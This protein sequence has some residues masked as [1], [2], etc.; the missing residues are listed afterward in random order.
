MINGPLAGKILRFAVPLMLSSVLQLLF[1]AA[2]VAVVGRFA[3]KDA[4]AAVGSTAVISHMLVSLGTSFSVGT[5]I[6]ISRDLGS[7][8]QDNT[9]C[10]V[11]T[12]VTLALVCG[13]LLGSISL[14]LCRPIL[15][16]MR[17][18]ADVIDLSALYL[19]LYFLG[20]PAIMLYNFGAAILR[21]Q[22]DTK[23]PLY[24]LTS[25]GIIN[26]CLNLLFV[27]VFHMSVAGVALATIASQ[28]ISAG[29]VF[30]TL[31]RE[32]GP[33]HLDPKKLR[34]DKRAVYRILKVGIPAG[35]QS[36]IF[37]VS[38]MAGQSAINSLNSTAVMAASSTGDNIAGFVYIS[39]NAFYQA[40]Q[41]F[42]SQNYGAGKCDRVDKVTVLSMLYISTAGLVLGNLAYFFGEELASLYVPGEQE[43]IELT[44][45]Y[46]RI[47]ALPYFICGLMEVPVGVMRSIGY[48]TL[49][50]IVYS[51]GV[52][53]LRLVW[54]LVIFPLMPTPSFLYL[55]YPVSWAVTAIAQYILLAILRKRAYRQIQNLQTFSS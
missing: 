27:I 2:D 13:F 25:A 43:V 30:I 31:M 16:L 49:P 55:A 9:S 48:Y 4:L 34:L 54:F 1:N 39:M 53:G 15:V 10:S 22:G 33:L 23:R 17:S 18:P 19:R 29:L 45:T 28:Y 35:I 44:V 12:S 41:T 11:H 32:Q 36:M 42:A 14:L 5:N 46:L 52:C 20:T 40:T 38:N 47:V 51:T 6:V 7:G 3:G 37:S 50:T 26:V 24:F 21:A 8:N